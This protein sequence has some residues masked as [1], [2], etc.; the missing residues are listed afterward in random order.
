MD[1]E[2]GLSRGSDER[3]SFAVAEAAFVAS[4]EM[5]VTEEEDEVEP[6]R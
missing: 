4:L 1:S 2:R 5:S 3:G 6:F